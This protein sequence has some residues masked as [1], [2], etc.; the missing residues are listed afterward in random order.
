MEEFARDGWGWGGGGGWGR[1]RG[2]GWWGGLVGG[3][4]GG[5]ISGERFSYSAPSVGFSASL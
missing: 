3:G 5:V 2:W 1:G 4:E